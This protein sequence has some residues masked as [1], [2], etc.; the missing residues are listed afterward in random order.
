MGQWMVMPLKV[1]LAAGQVLGSML[2]KHHNLE[3]PYG[4]EP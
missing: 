2:E 3:P 1:P 4:I